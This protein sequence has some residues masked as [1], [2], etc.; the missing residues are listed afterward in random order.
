M[1]Y[2][3]GTKFTFYAKNVRGEVARGGR[4]ISIKDSNFENSTGFT[5]YMDTIIRA[6]SLI[7]KIHKILIP[8]DTSEERKKELIEEGYILETFFDKDNEI[9]KIALEKQIKFYLVNNKVISI[10]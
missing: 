10:K 8:F 4:Y 7:D 5:C 2:H 3:T 1:D 6:S 9:K